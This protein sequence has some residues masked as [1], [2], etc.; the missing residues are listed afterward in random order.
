[1][2]T[3]PWIARAAS[4][5]LDALGEFA[6]WWLGTELGAAPIRNG[7][8]ADRFAL[9]RWFA[10]AA[11][12]HQN[13]FILDAAPDDDDLVPFYE[14]AQANFTLSV[15]PTGVVWLDDSS[16]EVG[17]LVQQPMSLAQ[18]LLQA[19]LYEC[20]MGADAV[21]FAWNVPIAIPTPFVARLTEVP[22][23]PWTSGSARFYA[24]DDVLAVVGANGDL[25]DFWL[26]AKTRPALDELCRGLDTASLEWG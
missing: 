17:G 14:E 16:A 18:C 11:R 4:H 12:S 26:G 21:A 15:D 9:L 13:Q 22:I 7:G 5:D 3:P 25:F 10:P 23:R 6:R 19:L 20:T 2:P 24:S 1:M 8:G